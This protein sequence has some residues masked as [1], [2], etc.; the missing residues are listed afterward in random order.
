[1]GEH[2]RHD[3]LTAIGGPCGVGANL[4]ARAPIAQPEATKVQEL[5]QFEQMLSARLGPMCVLTKQFRVDT[6][7]AGDKGKHGSRG[8]FRRTES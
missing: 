4:Q 6:H 1:M 2:C 8:N 5:L 7:L 3:W